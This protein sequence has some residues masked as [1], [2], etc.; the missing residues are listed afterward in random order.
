MGNVLI[1]GKRNTDRTIVE[2]IRTTAEGALISSSYETAVSRGEVLGA[3]PFG[4]YGEMATVGAVTNQIIWPDGTYLVPP[5]SG[6]QMSLV[7]TSAQDGVG[8]TG[9]RSVELHYL[10][11]ALI[12]RFETVVMNGLTP[13]LTVATN[14]RFIQCMHMIA[15]GSTKAAVGLI[16]AS[17]AGQPYSQIIIGAVRCTSSVRMVPAGKT[18]YITGLSGGSSSGTAAASAVIRLCAT[19][20]DGHDYTANSVFIPFASATAQDTSVTLSLSIPLPFTAGIAVGMQTTVDK[21]ATIVGSW[22]GWIEDA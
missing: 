8:G 3:E 21:A 19:Y 5:A 14:I 6:L 13:V 17:N 18:L 10:D 20:F 2:E 15:F 12:E 9:I 4:G 1:T 16:T 7:S 11:D 22:F